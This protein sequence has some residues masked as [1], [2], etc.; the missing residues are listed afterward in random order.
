MLKKS[1]IEKAFCPKLQLIAK[2]E[3]DHEEIEE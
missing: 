3:E 1:Q 2:I